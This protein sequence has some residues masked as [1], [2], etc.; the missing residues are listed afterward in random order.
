MKFENVGQQ[1]RNSLPGGARKNLAEKET[2]STGDATTG[3]EGGTV[4]RRET[5][6]MGGAEVAAITRI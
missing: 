5:I 4:G 1:Q 3:E 2:A 6:V